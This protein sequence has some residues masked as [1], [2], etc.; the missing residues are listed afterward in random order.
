M[1]KINSLL[2]EGDCAHDNCEL[3]LRLS[4]LVLVSGTS[5]SFVTSLTRAELTDL[6]NTNNSGKL[7]NQLSLL[8]RRKGTG[9][10]RMLQFY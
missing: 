4:T 6:H 1:N 2:I 8:S 5:I 10:M 7:E 3:K 9:E